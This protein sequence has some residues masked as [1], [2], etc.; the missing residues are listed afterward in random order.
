MQYH[1]LNEHT[2]LQ[3]VREGRVLKKNTRKH[4][5][6][7]PKISENLEAKKKAKKHLKKNNIGVISFLRR[8]Q[9]KKRMLYIHTYIS[10]CERAEK[11]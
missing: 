6:F 10:A 7:C 3:L 5:L 9:N 2:F 4:L 8:K 11:W 1:T